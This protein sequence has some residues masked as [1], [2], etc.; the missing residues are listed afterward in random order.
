MPEPY[1]DH[2]ADSQTALQSSNRV[3]KG[4][5]KSRFI[6]GCCGKIVLIVELQKIRIS[7]I[8]ID[9]DFQYD[10]IANEKQYSYAIMLGP[11]LPM[12]RG[13]AKTNFEGWLVYVCFACI[14]LHFSA[15]TVEPLSFG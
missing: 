2:D 13:V 15:F 9:E 3:T 1:H 14:F 8:I 12:P 6:V 5:V 7:S 11:I 4:R 10:I